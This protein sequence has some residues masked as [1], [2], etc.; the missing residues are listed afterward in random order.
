[1]GHRSN[2][3][4]QRRLYPRGLRAVFSISVRGLF[5]FIRL[6]IDVACGS[7]VEGVLADMAEGRDNP[8]CFTAPSEF[9]YRHGRG[10]A[11]L[12]GNCL[13]TLPWN[14]PF[15]R[16]ASGT[17]SGRPRPNS[18]SCGCSVFCPI[19]SGSGGSTVLCVLGSW[20][21]GATL[22]QNALLV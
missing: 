2:P 19:P 22:M 21:V 11:S 9:N 13:N 20:T 8:A 10:R 6:P 14:L 5:R 12:R 7:A 16:L 4:D 18:H 15:P 17:H 3:V 1:M